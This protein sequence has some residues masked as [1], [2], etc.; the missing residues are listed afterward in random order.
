MILKLLYKEYF[1]RFI[2]SGIL[3]TTI[4]FQIVTPILNIELDVDYNIEWSDGSD[5]SESDKIDI[6]EKEHK[7][8]FNKQFTIA[9]ELI[10]F[11]EYQLI[12][13]TKNHLSVDIDITL[14]PP[15]HQLS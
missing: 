2:T 7:K 9:S 4:L 11:T 1:T 13:D 3:V 5:S 10:Y 6:E 14:P 8:E 15:K 12:I